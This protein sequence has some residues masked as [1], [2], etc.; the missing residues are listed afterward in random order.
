MAVL[1]EEALAQAVATLAELERLKP[2]VTESLRHDAL[3]TLAGW[4]DVGVDMVP[5]VTSSA[6]SIA[7]Q[8]VADTDPPTLVVARS[9]S[10]RRQQ[11]SALHELGHHVQRNSGALLSAASRSRTGDP[12]ALEEAACEVFASR[13]LLPDALG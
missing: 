9:A 10:H 1:R 5:E 12:E 2:G 11:F 7:G 3:D 8:Y 13:I 4:S 6:C